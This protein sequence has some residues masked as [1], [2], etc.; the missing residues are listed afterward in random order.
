M[1]RKDSFRYLYHETLQVNYMGNPR[2][3]GILCVCMLWLSFLPA[4]F[5]LGWETQ[6]ITTDTRQSGESPDLVIGEDGTLH[7][8]YHNPWEDYV[9]YGQRPVGAT[10]WTFETVDPSGANGYRSAIALDTAGNVH[11]AYYEKSG[12]GI[13]VRYA[14][15]TAP[16]TWAIENL[17]GPKD[18]TNW[19]PYGKGHPDNTSAKLKNKIDLIFTP[20]NEPKVSFFHAWYDEG[21]TASCLFFWGNYRFYPVYAFKNVSDEWELFEFPWLSSQR[22][23]CACDT[24]P[25]GD[26]Y[27]EYTNIVLD[28]ADNPRIFCTSY[29]NSDVQMLINGGG[30]SLWTDTIAD[31]AE[32]IFTPAFWA[33]KPCGTFASPGNFQPILHSYTLE[34]LDATVA[35]DGA[36]HLSYT[37]SLDFGND[38]YPNVFSS[39]HTI[40]HVRIDTGGAHQQT[41]LLDYSTME[42]R[43]HKSWTS[44]VTI[45]V[46][47]VKLLYADMK[48]NFLVLNTSVDTG[49]NWAQDT[50]YHGTL[51]TYSPMEIEG[52]S[53]YIVV[54]DTEKDELVLVSQSLSDSTSTWHYS[55]ITTSEVTGE[56]LDA[57]FDVSGGD[58]LSQI[59]Y[60]ERSSGKLFLSE[61]LESGGSSTTTISEI[62][63][64]YTGFGAVSLE[65]DPTGR[66]HLVYSAGETGNLIYA[67]KPVGSPGN[68]PLLDT[69]K[70]VK[71]TDLYAAGEN[72]VHLVFHNEIDGFLYYAWKDST[73][74][75]NT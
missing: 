65:R 69:N 70:R 26:R 32:T 53:L 44:I 38:F 48:H 27:G 13:Q 24:V 16:G 35:S 46:D 71:Y 75:L 59:V 43:T 33:E 42:E 12:E 18:A 54:Y 73:W 17:P 6:D 15:R 64:T 45:G 55:Q 9:I 36:Y 11:I 72:D 25:R 63:T 74:Q 50:I 68:S 14:S 22:E 62:D 40:I 10:D 30:D 5:F 57:V 39:I 67:T 21:S 3:V 51:S 2:T 49:H 47:T 37:T 56:S 1:Q 19:G 58:T 34:A 20:Q 23:N 31:Q 4:Q 8:C 66:L 60:T 41:W 7:I 61:V 52:D 29:F 28:T